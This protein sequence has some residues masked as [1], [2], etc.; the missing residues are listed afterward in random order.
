MIPK[1]AK[2]PLEV[3]REKAK[4]ALEEN[5]D[6]LTDKEVDDA[7]AEID[8]DKEFDEERAKYKVEVW[9]RKS[10]INGV[11]AEDVLNKRNDIP[12]NSQVY[13]IKDAETDKVLMFQPHK[14][15]VQGL[16]AVED[17]NTEGN[18]HCDKIAGSRTAQKIIQEVRK[19]IEEK[20]MS[21]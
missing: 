14:P 20:R 8:Q 10:P 17:G 11:P 7:L 19:K 6:D 12:K 9:D 13:L 5:F 18:N 21:Q 1:H 3:D 4:R 15:E 2:P 16:Q